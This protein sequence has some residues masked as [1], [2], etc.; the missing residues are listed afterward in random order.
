MFNMGYDVVTA[1]ILHT[2]RQVIKQKFIETDK[3]MNIFRR[4][5]CFIKYLIKYNL[6]VCN[7]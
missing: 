7:Y 6:I 1:V 2:C 3:V 5:V 4:K